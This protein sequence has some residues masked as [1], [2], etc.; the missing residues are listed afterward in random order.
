MEDDPRSKRLSTMKTHEN[1]GRVKQLV[2]SDCRLTVQMI[3]DELSL[4]RNWC[5]S[6][7]C[8]IKV[9]LIIFFDQKGLVDH[10]YVPG[11]ETVN[12]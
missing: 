7:Y 10:E 4:N 12:M 2:Q 1:I 5:V 6:S 9:M 3:A 8:N 11:G